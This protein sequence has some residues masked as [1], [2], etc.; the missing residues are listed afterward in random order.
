MIN[1]PSELTTEIVKLSYEEV[2]RKGITFLQV[3][4]QMFQESNIAETFRKALKY[5]SVFI[6]INLLYLNVFIRLTLFFEQLFLITLE[7]VNVCNEKGL[8]ITNVQIKAFLFII[9]RTIFSML[10]KKINDKSR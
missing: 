5:L 1:E 7:V 8:N 9:L 10:T 6:L 3:F 4:P 2:I